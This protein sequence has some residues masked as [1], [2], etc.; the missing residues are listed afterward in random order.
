MDHVDYFVND[1]LTYTSY[2]EPFSVNFQTN[3]RQKGVKSNVGDRW[4]A[5]VYLA[6]GEA[7]ERSAEVT[8]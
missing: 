3:W 4:K 6:N 2:D 8:D 5:I 7:I 1:A